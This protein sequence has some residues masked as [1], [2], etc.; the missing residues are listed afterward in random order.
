MCQIMFANRGIGISGPQV[1]LQENIFVVHTDLLDLLGHRA[2][3]DPII[4]QA[5]DVKEATLEG[6]LSLPTMRVRVARSKEITLE[7][8]PIYN[9]AERLQQVYKGPAARCIQHEL[10]HLRGVL[11]FDYIP[12]KVYR[13]L[14]LDKYLKNR[15]V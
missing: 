2:F 10:D 9:R 3:I 12:S 14:T 1:G 13:R 6:C 11:I 4:L 7:Y 15:G 8:T 5:S